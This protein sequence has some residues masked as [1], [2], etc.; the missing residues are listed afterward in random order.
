MAHIMQLKCNFNIK[1][2][3]YQK[4]PLTLFNVYSGG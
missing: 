2:E 4:Q 3:G 1:S